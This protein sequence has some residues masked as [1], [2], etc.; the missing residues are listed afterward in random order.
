MKEIFTAIRSSLSARLSLAVVLFVAVIFVGAFSIMFTEAQDIIKEEAWGKASQTLDG[1]VLHID[2]TLR[3]VEVAS[4]NMLRVIERNLEKPDSMFTVGKQVLA[5]NRELTGCS[6]SFDPFYY[7]EKGRYF[8]AYAYNDGDSILTEQEG[9]DNY[10]YHCMDWYLIPKLLDRPYWIEP[11]MEDATEGIIVKDIFSSYSRPIHDAKG[12]SVGTFSVDIRLSWFTQTIAKVKPYPHSFCVM[13][14]KGGSYL[15]HPDTTK[16]FYETIFTR[17]LEKP[18]SQK[19]ALG[20]SML[21]GE[22]GHKILDYDGEPCHVFY[23]PFKNT[24]WSVAIVIPERDIYAP[25]QRLRSYTLWISAAGL[26][27][28]LFFS[29]ITIRNSMKPLQQLAEATHRIAAGDFSATE[30]RRLRTDEIGQLQRSFTKMQ[31][32]LDTYTHELRSETTTLEKRNQEL[33]EAYE[34]AKEDERMKT[35]I[36]HKMPDKMAVPVAEISTTAKQVC[37]HL[38]EQTLDI[39][40]ATKTMRDNADQITVLLDEMIRA[41]Q[42]ERRQTHG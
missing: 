21:A 13:L 26:L 16:L 3:R 37:D 27:L 19:T 8:S 5:N 10:Q 25:Y 34:R 31:Q 28:L 33:L 36:L 2:N 39:K 20:T 40:K 41:A 6:I 11:F 24:G 15:V 35:A 22:S 7:K 29:L 9:T 12:N 30:A 42:E 23:K 38:G 32:S 1:T 4:D 18:D 14:G 17:T